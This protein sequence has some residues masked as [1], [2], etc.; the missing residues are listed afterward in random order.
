MPNIGDLVTNLIVDASQHTKG[1]ELAR[2]NNRALSGSIDSIIGQLERQKRAMN[3]QG[4][5]TQDNILAQ[6]A[7]PGVTEGAVNVALQLNEE[8]TAKRAQIE[9]ENEANA[10]RQRGLAVGQSLVQMLQQEQ[11]EYGMTAAQVRLSG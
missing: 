8:V 4:R 10:A 11:A 6:A 7:K 5:T 1:T 3:A 9:A 2:G